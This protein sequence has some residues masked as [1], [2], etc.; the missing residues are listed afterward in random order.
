MVY[1]LIFEGHKSLSAQDQRSGILQFAGLHEIPV[2]KF[3][4]FNSNPNILLFQSGDTVVCYAWSCL[5]Q[6]MSFLRAFIMH[7]VRNGVNLYSVTSEYHIDSTMDMNALGYAIAAYEDIRFNFWSNKT[8]ESATK[9]AFSG[10]RIGD[11]NKT[12]ILD[13]REKAVWDMYNNG[14]SMY[15]IAKKMKVSAPT[16]KRFLSSQN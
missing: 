5:C 12:H 1:G 11:R 9:R 15:A 6:K 7:L 13:G 8:A 16:I 10:R 14:F 3:I 2:D 4:S